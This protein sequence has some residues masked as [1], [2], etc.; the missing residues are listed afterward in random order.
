MS[1]TM[2]I[3]KKTNIANDKCFNCATYSMI[4]LMDVI[5]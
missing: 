4:T 1:F 2:Q 3:Y 5:L